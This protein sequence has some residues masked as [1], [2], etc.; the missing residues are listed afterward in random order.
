[1]SRS[2]VEVWRKELA[3]L[4]NSFHQRSRYDRMLPTEGPIAVEWALGLTGPL[5]DFI[6]HRRL[7]VV[8]SAAGHS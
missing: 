8:R 2:T 5:L 1:M 3:A 6:R 4:I 7:R